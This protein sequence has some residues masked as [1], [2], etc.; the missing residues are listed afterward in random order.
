[1]QAFHKRPP[2]HVSAGKK[3]WALLFDPEASKKKYVDMTLKDMV[4]KDTILQKQAKLITELREQ[5][6]GRAATVAR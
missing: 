6:R 3:P 1:M 2:E 5:L 4:I